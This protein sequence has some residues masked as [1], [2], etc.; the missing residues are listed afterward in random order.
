M[1]LM[2][3]F[4]TRLSMLSKRTSNVQKKYDKTGDIDKRVDMDVT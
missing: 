3:E 4:N 2:I 1:S